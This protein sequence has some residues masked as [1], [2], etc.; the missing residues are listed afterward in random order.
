[1]RWVQR[2]FGKRLYCVLV[3][4]SILLPPAYCYGQICYATVVTEALSNQSLTWLAPMGM[5]TYNY[6]VTVNWNC[7]GGAF[8]GRT[9]CELDTVYILNGNTYAFYDSLGTTDSATAC[10]SVNNQSVWNAFFTLPPSSNFEDCV[11]VESIYQQFALQCPTRLY[12]RCLQLL[13]IGQWVGVLRFFF[14]Q[15]ASAH[16]RSER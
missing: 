4:A 13:C 7:S 1:M 8:L 6:T 2:L 11:R 14:V 15:R 16:T 9:V 3:A 5:Y 12:D 10:S